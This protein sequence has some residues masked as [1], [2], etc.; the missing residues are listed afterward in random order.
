MVEP[1]FRGI[2]KKQADEKYKVHCSA[3]GAEIA[4]DLTQDGI[5]HLAFGLLLHHLEEVHGIPSNSL[6]NLP[7]E[8][9]SMS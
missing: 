6:P 7:I 8:G 1:D 9:L 4:R 2:I 3:C 5:Y